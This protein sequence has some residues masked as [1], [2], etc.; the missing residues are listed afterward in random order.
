MTGTLPRWVSNGIKALF[1]ALAHGTLF[2]APHVKPSVRKNRVRLP[3]V[4]PCRL[5]LFESG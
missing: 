2:R 4:V 1:R 3:T 5:D